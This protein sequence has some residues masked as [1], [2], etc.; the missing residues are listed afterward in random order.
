MDDN[1]IKYQIPTRLD[2]TSKFLFWDW[3]V[4][5]VA[6]GVAYAGI[7]AGNFPVW[8]IAGIGL[9]FLYSKL[10]SGR[11]PGFSIHLLYWYLPSKDL[12]RRTPPSH[13]R[14]FFG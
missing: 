14:E 13:I 4:A 6:I 8:M 11:H 7:W 12:F 1:E 9:A 5:A 2:E 10:K 3:D